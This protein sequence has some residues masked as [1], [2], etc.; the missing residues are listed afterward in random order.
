MYLIIVPTR[1]FNAHFVYAFATLTLYHSDDVFVS[2]CNYYD[3]DAAPIINPKANKE[4]ADNVK[5]L[6][7]KDTCQSGGLALNVKEMKCCKAGESYN[8]KDKECA[9]LYGLSKAS[10]GQCSFLRLIFLYMFPM[11]SNE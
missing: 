1:E 4:Q 2:I 11:L 6:I 9:A 8:A 5:Y 7:A 3:R 10:P